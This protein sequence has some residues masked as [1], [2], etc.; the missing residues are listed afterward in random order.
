MS[1]VD[2]VSLLE[3]IYPHFFE[4]ENIKNLPDEWICDEM[5]LFLDE[6]EPDIYH[7]KLD[8]HISFGCF[9][10][11]LADLKK[12]VAKIVEY[13]V[14]FYNGKHRAYCG[15]VDGKIASFCLIEDMGEHVIN[16]CKIKVGGPGCVGTLPEYRNKGIGMTMVKK[17]TQILK[18]EGYDCSYIHFTGV[19]L[20]Y[21]KIGYKSSVKWN[22]NGVIY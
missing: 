22:K 2:G 13:W 3:S 4:R 19:P 5:V 8:E 7:K 14:D 18:N 16:G 9:E 20:W 11:D 12:E 21:E 15:Y 17:V 6:F 1:K 10:G